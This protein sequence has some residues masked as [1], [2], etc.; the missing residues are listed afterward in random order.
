MGLWIGFR[1]LSI[2]DCCPP[3]NNIPE[4]TK[5]ISLFFDLGACPQF[6]SSISI[7]SFFSLSHCKIFPPCMDWHCNLVPWLLVMANLISWLPTTRRVL[8]AIGYFHTQAFGTLFVLY[9]YN[10]YAPYSAARITLNHNILRQSRIW[11]TQAL[12]V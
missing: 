9:L 1:E 12:L 11:H 7:I 6:K 4:I 10:R 3:V 2:M 5:K 8:K